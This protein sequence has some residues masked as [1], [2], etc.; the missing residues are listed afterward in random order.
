MQYTAQEPNKAQLEVHV[1]SDWAGDSNASEQI[2]SDCVVL[3]HSS[4]AQDVIGHLWCR[5]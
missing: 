2:C 1:D 4:R 3:R 5:K